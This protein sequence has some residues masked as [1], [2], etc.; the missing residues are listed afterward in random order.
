MFKGLECYSHAPCVD[1]KCPDLSTTNKTCAKD[2]T[3]CWVN[4]SKV[5][6]RKI[7]FFFRKPVFQGVQCVIVVCIR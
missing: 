1:S 3:K 7:K 6:F 5:F 4:I 2:E